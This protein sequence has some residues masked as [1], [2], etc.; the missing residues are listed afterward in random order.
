MDLHVVIADEI[1]DRLFV[2]G[3]G[4]RATQLVLTD[5]TK[6]G[7]AKNL[8]GWSRQAVEDVIVEVLR[9]TQEGAPHA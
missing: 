5:D 7:E 8:G 9:G 3:T 2:N 6:I 1:A 4:Q